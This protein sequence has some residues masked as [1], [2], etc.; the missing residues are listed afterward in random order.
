MP[1]SSDFH[2]LPSFKVWLLS[3]ITLD[4]VSKGKRLGLTTLPAQLATGGTIK[5]LNHE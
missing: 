2:Q 3:N 5:L 4:A 1:Q